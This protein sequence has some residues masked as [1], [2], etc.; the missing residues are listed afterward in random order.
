M[1][2][3]K[4]EKQTEKQPA[5]KI[6]ASKLKLAESAIDQIEKQFGKGSIMRLADA[7]PIT[8]DAISTGSISFDACLGIGVFPKEELL[9]YSD[10]NLPGKQLF[11]CM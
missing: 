5:S 9:K 7:Q 4:A 1:A 6:D 10:P 2:E 3:S 8:I 11:V